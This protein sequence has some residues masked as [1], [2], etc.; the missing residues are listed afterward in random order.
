V[1]TDY[2]SSIIVAYEWWSDTGS[3]SASVS[4]VPFSFTGTIQPHVDTSILLG[5]V[6]ADIVQKW[7]ENCEEG[8]P[9]SYMQC[10]L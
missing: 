2:A 9:V 10:Y 8:T 6:G 5:R 7:I 4:L 3:L 1:F